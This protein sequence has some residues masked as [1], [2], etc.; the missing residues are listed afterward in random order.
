[1]IFNFVEQG[2]KD[3]YM[4]WDPELYA[5]ITKVRVPSDKVWTPD[6]KLYN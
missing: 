6:I 2:W 5:N 4:S 1:M 3:I